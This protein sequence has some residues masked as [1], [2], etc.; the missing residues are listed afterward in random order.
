[1]IRRVLLVFALMAPAL[2][3]ANNCQITN[4]PAATLLL[5]Y[6]EVEIARPVGDA[7]NTIFTIVNTSR[8][9]QNARVTI[10]SDYG[11][12]VLWFDVFLTGYDAQPISLYD[13]LARG[14]IPQTSSK[15]PSGSR[16]TAASSQL[17]N[18]SCAASPALPESAIK[19]VQTALTRGS[20][21]SSEC[22]IGG[23]HASA[24]G[25]LTIDVTR[26]C[27]A[28]SPN[29]PS[30]YSHVLGH[31]NVLTGDYEHVFPDRGRGNFAGGA[32]FVHIKSIPPGTT[33]AT[34][35]DRYTP[36]GARTIDRR[37]PLPSSFAARFIQGGV[38]SFST[39]F[40][41]WR[42]GAARPGTPCISANAALPVATIIRFD[43]EEN[44]TSILPAAAATTPAAAALLTNDPMFPPASGS[45]LAG[46]ILIDLDNGASRGS[47]ANPYSTSRASQNWVVVRMRAEGRYG[48]DYDAVPLG[49]VCG[50]SAVVSSLRGGR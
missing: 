5:P 12:P 39:E 20:L 43:E 11:H 41:I 7:A 48:I 4:S 21:E 38:T 1:M 46:W 8:A 33:N 32:S 16:S 22:K 6:F 45:T 44:P 40:V 17:L 19:A 18:D 31:D 26:S 9:S 49:T 2:A 30:Y 24:T 28:L 42:E 13:V 10:W 37:Q 14:V 34:F 47:A 25:Y 23:S 3:N 27:S 15:T 29:D 35:Y 50:P 36:Q